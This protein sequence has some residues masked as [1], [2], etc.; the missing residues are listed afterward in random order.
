MRSHGLDPVPGI[1]P[2]TYFNYRQRSKLLQSNIAQIP[3]LHRFVMQD[4]L[5]TD[6]QGYYDPS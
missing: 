2:P 1:I 3:R 6:N 4:R 5:W